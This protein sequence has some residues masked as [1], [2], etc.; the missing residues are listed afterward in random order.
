[1]NTLLYILQTLQSIF[2]FLTK[3][4]PDDKIQEQNQ[5]IN[6]PRLQAEQRIALINKE[7]ARLKN[8]PSLSIPL[9]ISFVDAN[10]NPED[11]KELTT[12]VEQRILEYRKRHPIIFKNWLKTQSI[13]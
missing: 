2:T 1:M 11:Q 10:L 7:F 8:K 5:I 6:L 13:K 3:V 9:E 4:T 12:I